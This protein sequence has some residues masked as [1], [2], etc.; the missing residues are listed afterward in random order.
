MSNISFTDLLSWLKKDYYNTK[1]KFY[2]SLIL[3]LVQSIYLLV[4]YPFVRI[5]FNSQNSQVVFIYP[6][7]KAYRLNKQKILIQHFLASDISSEIHVK[8]LND[9][10]R[11]GYRPSFD[12][13]SLLFPKTAWRANFL[14]KKHISVKSII[15]E[16]YDAP[17]NFFLSSYKKKHQRI[18]FLAHSIITN[19]SP[20]FNLVQG[21]D[22]IVF[23]ESSILA[24]EKNPERLGVANLIKS[25]PY[26]ID[27]INKWR[28]THDS[29]TI[30]LVA[31]GPDFEKYTHITDAYRE[32]NSWCEKEGITLHIKPHP[33]GHGYDKWGKNVTVLP[34]NCKLHHIINN[35]IGAI[36]VYSNAIVDLTATG[37]PTA[38]YSSEKLNDPWL[39]KEYLPSFTSASEL[40]KFTQQC[41]KNSLNLSIK[42]KNFASFHWHN[43]DNPSLLT[44]N[45]IKNLPPE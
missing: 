9:I 41:K 40:Q 29:K 11:L 34:T 22:Y 32:I 26:F 16:R 5:T 20:K 1:I 36:C 42:S 39:A 18:T 23:G 17:F 45:I 12:P 44:A 14:L 31:C 15:V 4:I 35:Y 24:I 6:S 7:E 28:T 27:H 43:L 25:G 19:D 37:I 13:R 10:L 30:L 21:D 3:G 2:Y 33:L 8:K 38:I